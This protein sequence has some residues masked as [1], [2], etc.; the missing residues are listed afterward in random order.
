ME[1]SVVEF[2]GISEWHKEG[3]GLSP[4]SVVPRVFYEVLCGAHESMHMKYMEVDRVYLSYSDASMHKIRES[5]LE[6]PIALD[7]PRT[8]GFFCWK[9]SSS[10]EFE[11]LVCT[12]EI[13]LACGRGQVAEKWW[14]QLIVAIPSRDHVPRAGVS[15]Y[16]SPENSCFLPLCAP[17]TW[18]RRFGL[19]SSPLIL[20]NAKS[21]LVVLGRKKKIILAYF[22]ILQIYVGVWQEVL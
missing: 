21:F 13:V 6:H 1:W 8:F 20:I 9:V 18:G 4:D 5:W 3:R 7:L 16:S 12:K 2:F 15:L 22:V 11:S 17:Q 14:Y 19:I 10:W